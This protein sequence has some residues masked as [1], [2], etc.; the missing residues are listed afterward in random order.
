MHPLGG[1]NCGI[2]I[3]ETSSAPQI[4]LTPGCVRLNHFELVQFG[5]G[6]PG[7]GDSFDEVILL[8]LSTF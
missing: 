5:I 7:G 1:A 6:S 2:Y 8:L 4:K 3:R